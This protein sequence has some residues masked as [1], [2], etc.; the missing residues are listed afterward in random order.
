LASHRYVGSIRPDAATPLRR[1]RRQACQPRF[2]L[3]NYRK[4]AARV[5]Q[6]REGFDRKPT[7]RLILP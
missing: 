7:S 5:T 1:P 6:T 4:K 2:C 3:D